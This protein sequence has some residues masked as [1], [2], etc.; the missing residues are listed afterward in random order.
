VDKDSLNLNIKQLKQSYDD[1]SRD[2][3]ERSK[4]KDVCKLLD[5]KAS[6]K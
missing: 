2:V 6:T 5:L 4:I 1:I 3:S